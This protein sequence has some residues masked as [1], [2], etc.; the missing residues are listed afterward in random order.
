MTTTAA[1]TISSAKPLSDEERSRVVDDF[2]RDGFCHVPAV[3]TPDEIA[4]ARATID[5]IF[6]DPK[7]TES[8]NALDGYIALRLFEIDPFF[9]QF[10]TREPLISLAEAIVGPDCHFI[11]Q[12]AIRNHPGKAID[13]FHVD[14]GV[15]FPVN[16]GVE[17]H[18][19][20]LTLPVFIA[21]CTF[22]LSDVSSL[23]YGPT[24]V[25]PG[26]HY[27][28]R[29]PNDLKDPVFEGKHAVPIF[30]KA[31]DLYLFNNQAWHR[32]APNT[33]D[34]TRYV[35]G[36][37]YARRFMAQRFYPYMGYQLPQGMSERADPRRRR[38][39]GLHEKGAYG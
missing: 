17:R 8:Y 26:S 14:D 23:E 32:G 18:D 19:P 36:V 13:T 20:R 7:Y 4:T 1:S 37:G 29:Q 10:L 24:Q 3:L 12:N 25:V 11:S 16:N 21:N 5:R 31:G 34:R 28:G 30:C 2:H 6:D 15:Y 33:S 35:F 22:A 9:E 27:S 39:L 38:V